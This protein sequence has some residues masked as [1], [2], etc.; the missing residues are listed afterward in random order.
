[1]TFGDLQQEVLVF[2]RGD[3]TIKD[4]N[5]KSDFS[6]GKDITSQGEQ[7]EEVKAEEKVKPV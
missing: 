4:L 5:E 6:T 7:N 1:M 2:E 3:S